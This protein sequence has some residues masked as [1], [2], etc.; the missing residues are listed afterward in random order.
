MSRETPIG[1]ASF[2]RLNKGL[3]PGPTA[4]AQPPQGVQSPVRAKGAAPAE[5]LKTQ[6]MAVSGAV[7]M[8]GEGA[9]KLTLPYPPSAN[10]YWR[11]FAYIDKRSGKPKAAIFVSEEAKRYKKGIATLAGAMLK[12]TGPV[13]LRAW[14][15]RPLRRGDLGNRMKVLEDAMEGVVYEDDEQIEYEEL[16][17]RDDKLNP[18]VEVEVWCLPTERQDSLPL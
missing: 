12:L 7:S 14:V 13:G 2:R 4:G 8:T 17:R 3:L 15:Y 6:R 18:R 1:S 5:G 16:F 9:W 11:T 10:R